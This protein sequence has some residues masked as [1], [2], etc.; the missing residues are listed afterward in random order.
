[1]SICERYNKSG[2]L[3]TC[4]KMYCDKLNLNFN[5]MH[6]IPSRSLNGLFVLKVKCSFKK[7]I[8]DRLEQFLVS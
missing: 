1:M 5:E 6:S 4:L 2:K 7:N 3:K 8:I